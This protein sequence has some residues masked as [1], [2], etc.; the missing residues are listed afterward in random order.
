MRAVAQV[1][2]SL[3]QLP[4]VVQEGSL[5]FAAPPIPPLA[6]VPLLTPHLPHSY[7]HVYHRGIYLLAVVER[8]IS[9]LLV[10]EFLRKLFAILLE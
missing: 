5:A 7:I 10:I 6:V 4:P 1:T 8:D 9:P 2:H 3:P